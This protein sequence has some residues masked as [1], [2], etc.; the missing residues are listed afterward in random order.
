MKRLLPFLL[1]AG[2][3]LGV[4]PKKLEA[5][6]PP[7]ALFNPS[8]YAGC[9]PLT[10]QFYNAS[11]GIGTYGWNFNDPVSGVF[12]TST[13]CSPT[14]TFVNPGSYNVQLTFSTGMGT[15]TY[16]ATIVVH[17]LPNPLINGNDTLCA[18]SIENYTV[19]GSPGSSYVWTSLGGAIQGANTGTSIN[20][21]WNSPGLQ[22][23]SVTETNTF[24]C[25]KTKTIKVLVA[26]QPK[27]GRVC[28]GKR[29]DNSGQGKPDS[30]AQ[31]LPCLCQYNIQTLQA[32]DLNGIPLSNA[33]YTF[34]WT[35]IGG[36]VQSGQGTNTANIL[37]GAGP[38][39]TVKIFVFN[40][41][42]CVDSS[43]CVYDV[44]PSPT[45]SFTADTAC[46]TAP[47][48]FNASGS[49]ILSQIINF[50]WTF[51]P[52]VIVNT[53]TPF[54]S[55]TFPSAGTYWVKLKVTSA[56][57]CT[58]D[59]LIKIKVNPGQAPPIACPGTVCHN[60][61]SC[62]S[63][64]FYAGATY[65]WNV[66]GGVGT[67]SANGDSICITWGAGPLGT[68]S[69]EVVNGPYLCAKN[70]IQI[71]IFP[72]NLNIYSVDTACLNEDVPVSTDLIPGSCYSWS[73][74]GPGSPTINYSTN[75]GH[76]ATFKPILP[77]IYTVTLN[78]SHE[79]TCC[80]GSKTK[81]IVVQPSIQLFNVNP[82]CEYQTGFYNAIPSVYWSAN[83]GTVNF[84]AIGVASNS[85]NITWGAAS[86]G[87]ITVIAQNPN[88][89]CKDKI[90]VPVVL[91]PRPPNPAINGP[92]ILCKG[93]TG[94]YCYDSVPAI[95]ASLYTIT[96]GGAVI[97]TPT[98][99]CTQ[100]TFNT[101]GTYT[102]TANYSG[103]LPT[104]CQ[105]SASLTIVV[106]DTVR[107]T[108][109]G[110]NS[111][112]IGSTYTYTMSSNPGNAYQWGVIGGTITA[113]TA[114][115]V[116][117]QW[118]NIST[119]QVNITN[120]VCPKFRAYNVTVNNMPTGIITVGKGG[121]KGD[122]VRLTGPPGYT[123]LWSTGATT[124]SI[125]I[126]TIGI[127]TLQIIKFGCTTTLSVNVNP[128]PKLPKPSVVVTVNCMASPT[129]PVPIQMQ[130]T[131]NPLWS[132]AW[133]PQT[134]TPA[135]ADTTFQH[136]STV[137]SSNH[138]VVVT[139]QFGCKDTFSVTTPSSCVITGGGGGSCNCAPTISASYDQCNGD[140]TASITGQ[141][142]SAVLWNFGDGTYSNLLNPNHYFAI[143]GTYSVTLSVLCSN[144]C[145][146]TTKL[147]ITVNYILRPKIK[148][149]FPV[150]CNYNLVQLAYT[151]LSNVQTTGGYPLSYSTDWG[152]GS[153]I[154]TTM[155]SISH[156]YS[157]PGTY[158]IIHTVSVPGC[159]KTVRDTVTVVP[160]KADFSFCNGCVGQA[161]QFA[162]QSLSPVPIVSWSWNFG[163]ATSS[164]LQNPF[165]IYNATGT[166]TVTL[167]IVNQQGC[168]STISYPVTVTVFNAGTLSY[169]NN[170]SP[171]IPN[172]SQTYTIC[173][174]DLFIATAPF[175]VNWSYAW[176]NGVTGNK[177]TIRQSGQY[178]VIVAN[179]NGCTDTLGSFTVIIN[180]KPNATILAPATLCLNQSAVINALTGANYS[181]YTWT[182]VPA[183]ISGFGSTAYLFNPGLNTVYL[184]VTNTLGCSASDTA[185]VTVI[186]GPTVSFNYSSTGIVCEGDSVQ[187]TPVISGAYI[188]YT[189]FN[190]V[191][192]TPIWVHANGNYS[193]TVT[194]PFGCNIT[195]TAPV[196]QITKRP[197]VRNVPKGCY[198]V[199]KNAITVTVCGP[200]PLPGQTLTYQ[201]YH[202]NNP[203]ATTQNISITLP[204][205]YYVVVNDP[206]V[207]CPATSSTFNV[208]VV[209]GPVANIVSPSPNPFICIGYPNSFQ[210]CQLN[211]DAGTLYTWYNGNTPIA[212][213]PCITVTTPGMYILEASIGECC[214][215]RDTIIVSE[216][217]CCFPPN[218][219]FTLIQDG[220]IYTTDQA[221]DG[222]YYVAGK[223]Y[224]RNKAV[225]DMTEIDVVFD[226]DGEIIFEDSS[227]IRATNSVF[228]PCHMHDVW[229]GLT[230]KDSSSG[231]CQANNFKNAEHGVFVKTTGPECVRLTDNLFSN[232]NRGIHINRMG[233]QEKVLPWNQG[234]TNNSIVIDNTN[235]N[236]P[237]LYNTTN[238]YGIML[239]NGIFEELISTNDIRNSDHTFQG[240]KLFGI[241]MRNIQARV[242]DNDFTNC[243]RAE[244]LSNP[245]G[246]VYIE[247]NHHTQTWSNKFPI[248]V[249]TRVS[250]AK[251]PVVIFANDY[252]SSDNASTFSSA[253]YARKC[254]KMNIRDNN[255]K[256]FD[257]G[258]VAIELEGSQINENDVD[259]SGD[260]GIYSEL[261]T[262]LDINCNVIRMKDM[263]TPFPGGIKS[264]G[265]YM[266]NGNNTNQI[267]T[268]CI[269]DTRYAIVV[270]R[271]SAILVPVPA[272]Y[273]NYMYN[274]IRAGIYSI[275][276]NGPIGFAGAPGRN[277]FVCN[278]KGGGGFDIIA[279]PALSISQN[280]NDMATALSGVAPSAC[281]ASAMFSSTAACG[282]R[283]I[284][285]NNYRQDKWDV[286]DVFTEKIII[287]HLDGN[288]D[289]LSTRKLG[290]LI[291]E[292]QS[293]QDA[294]AVAMQIIAYG[295]KADF[296]Y[297]MQA[298]NK[299]GK[300]S[301]GQQG[302][303]LAQW[304]A[305][306]QNYVLAMQT[307][308]S[309]SGLSAEEQQMISLLQIEISLAQGKT[310]SS[311][312]KASLNQIEAGDGVNAARA[313]DILQSL[314]GLFEYKFVDIKRAPEATEY[315]DLQNA[316]GSI[317]VV[318]NPTNKFADVLFSQ[319]GSG[320]KEISLFTANGSRIEKQAYE[321]S[322]GAYRFNMS[323]LSEGIYFVRIL[324][325]ETGKIHTA[326]IVKQ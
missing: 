212:N 118:G 20:V 176:N 84:P 190:G 275:W 2:L 300:F 269:S 131:Y 239:E 19:T 139:N 274:Y 15:F 94:T 326:K 238:F 195:L 47:T 159:S 41:F 277:T 237:L 315:N 52:G 289:S 249:Q 29:R 135:S 256:G 214:K 100:I 235:F 58:D 311:N 319:N 259:L 116:T 266:V 120:T 262:K 140:F 236:T 22:T 260:I 290:E 119:G 177:D 147:T 293:T 133:T 250:D 6:I 320:K 60:T 166:Y 64:P 141:S 263:R 268:N 34:N 324:D 242:S 70:T 164:N 151:P 173:E 210:L 172:L 39:M 132:Y 26:N 252:S 220:T 193:I 257:R 14:H 65:I 32:L 45:A 106:I 37:V 61:R 245:R 180:R 31:S 231:F 143:P 72:A 318:P 78:Q 276:H 226:R 171:V 23:L 8:T 169:T 194:S 59:T 258:I 170:G 83:N 280:C 305:A 17:P 136:Y 306:Q 168:S 80:K 230:F 286:C 130:A 270:R 185:T 24:G 317:K 278:N 211:P 295:K 192:N 304:Y 308:N 76:T 307:L 198:R 281:P 112:C 167:T 102:L 7:P 30:V 183:G 153:A 264:V 302:M 254:V 206:A 152:D 162:D 50:Q 71:P 125:V 267:Y 115:T 44:C 40:A 205:D 12:N 127:Y 175:N 218:T 296:D 244:D 203:Y 54:A 89:V 234:I 95:R 298:M 150:N 10:V 21:A 93:Q 299:A 186:G 156:T 111:V 137:L 322:E 232:C 67:P 103:A 48:N 114:T 4:L 163:D 199:C 66:T 284:N 160:F 110:P 16:N 248:D 314:T 158:I 1:C 96:P 279:T 174:G 138:T 63:T 261:C 79:L 209:P 291:P 189:W 197:D 154:N 77:G 283:I 181:T 213:G 42:G 325:I 202:N 243:Y 73:V 75:A 81:T 310:L 142:Y 223:V 253:I 88:L 187:I 107:P 68:I 85:S 241:H 43:I 155:P 82:I 251:V 86:Y 99:A 49:S 25:K 101:P 240:N 108:I 217:D 246:I 104:N 323:D 97:A 51:M 271:T 55:Y 200:Y 292:E 3:L 90:T 294:M 273:N 13:A 98:K 69:L 207:N 124:Q 282:Q 157:T 113:Q 184:T 219:Q 144:G 228:R 178:F 272:I 313:R 316:E 265:I 179:G 227:I 62:Y 165:K 87:S 297:W 321:V 229:V 105:S 121:C 215:S 196:W 233:V 255:I 46:L 27:L 285:N 57:G 303:L 123:Y 35:V 122:T 222:K 288:K 129:L 74:T 191:I 216:G 204:G 117:V 9:A 287:L 92:V 128:I 188:D 224:V 145:W 126:N 146:A 309:L 91:V 28:E 247:K 5:K 149:S 221:W 201:W 225:L 134:T 53:N 182:S 301:A 33:L 36:T 312:E 38:T 161:I 109:S 18:T 148:A 56:N 208:V 11:T